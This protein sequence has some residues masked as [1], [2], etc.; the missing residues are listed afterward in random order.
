MPEAAVRLASDGGIATITLDHPDKLNVLTA[1]MLDQLADAAARIEADPEVRVAILCGAGERAFC[2]GA[3]ITAWGELAPLDMWRRW[4]RDGHRV[5]DR[6]ARLRQPLIAA[7]NGHALGGGLEI[8]ATA[9]LRIVE[10]QAKF[11]LPEVSIGTVPG[12]SGTQRLVRRAGAQAVRR[13]ALTGELIAADEALR[14]GL[15]DEVVPTGQAM[16]RARALAEAIMGRAPTAVQ[17]AKVLINAAEG[18]ET[19][20]GL[21]GIAGA[22][23]ASTEDAREGVAAFRGKRPPRFKGR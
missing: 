18:E 14:L 5:F 3:D 19:A 13:L 17:I 7:I 6:L 21:E 12:W 16:F 23:A 20:A 1:A 2:A 11:G 15:V 10:T 4:I 9:D 8:A 22:L